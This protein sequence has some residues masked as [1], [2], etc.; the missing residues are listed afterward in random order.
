MCKQSFNRKGE[1]KVLCELLEINDSKWQKA[2][3]G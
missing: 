2:V 1:T 3:E